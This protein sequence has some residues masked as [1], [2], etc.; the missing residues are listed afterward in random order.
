[1]LGALKSVQEDGLSGNQA[2]DLHGVPRSTL[3]DR[4]SGRVKHGVKP[5][6]QPYLSA[7]KESELASHLLQAADMGFG[8]TRRDVKCVV[9]EHLQRKGTLKGTS[10]SNGWWEKFLRRNPNLS[11]RSGDSTAHVRMDAVN[12]E[13]LHSYYHLLKEVYDENGFADH[14]E[15]IYNMD[16]TGVPLEPRPPKVVAAKGKK[17]I[18]YRTSGQKSQITVIGCASASGQILPPF[19]IFAAKQLNELW[20]RNEVTGSRY[21][22]SD[23]GWVDQELFYFWLKVHFIPNAISQRPLLLLLDGHSSHFEPGTIQHARDN[24][25]IIFCLPPHT[26]HE[27][28][29]LDCSLFGPLKK[30]WQESCHNFYQTNPGKVISK[31]NFNSVFRSAWLNAVTPANICG[32][33]RKAGVYPYNPDAVEIPD[34]SLSSGRES[35]DTS[36][37]SEGIS[38]VNG[39]GDSAGSGGVSGDSAGSGGVSGD[40]SGASGGG[41]DGTEIQTR[42]PDDSSGHS[43]TMNDGKFSHVHASS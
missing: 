5:G 8:K 17:K 25:I 23:K 32:G 1:M 37:G 22:V 35:G 18:R 4:L 34:S 7:E 42:S 27:C 13:N 9:Q 24:N 15:A 20:T 36:G 26:T 6:P 30:H 16:E 28:Q 43:G 3:K 31:L 41:G 39:S 10:V 12:A 2:A 29:P 38:T 33:F 11:L 14:P 19:I 40:S 21:A